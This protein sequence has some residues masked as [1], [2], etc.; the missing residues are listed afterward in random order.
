MIK[1]GS[2]PRF[3]GGGFAQ[4]ASKFLGERSLVSRGGFR[5][6]AREDLTEVPFKHQENDILKLPAILLP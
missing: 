6:N 4:H 3:I 5:P 1:N 2:N